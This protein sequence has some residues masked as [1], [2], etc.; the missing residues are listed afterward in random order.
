MGD[1]AESYKVPQLI[2]GSA[3]AVAWVERVPSDRVEI[4]DS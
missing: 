4:S 1:S 2:V 3:S